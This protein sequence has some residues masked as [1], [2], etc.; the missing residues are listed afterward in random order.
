MFLDLLGRR[1]ALKNYSGYVAGLDTKANTTGLETYVSEFQ[2]FPI[3]FLV[4]TML[5]FHEGANEQVGR[6]RHVGNS[7]VTF[8]FQEP[9][10]LPFEVDSILSRFQQ[11]FI[12]IR[13]LKSNGP[14]P[15]YR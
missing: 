8:V 6:K 3:T 13:L 12:V 9:D 7:S 11:V 1:V 2:G 15:Q 4:S 14:L 10:A 5:P